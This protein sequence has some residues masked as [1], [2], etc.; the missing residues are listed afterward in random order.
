[1]PPRR[2]QPAADVD[3]VGREDLGDDP[4]VP[5]PLDRLAANLDPGRDGLEQGHHPA[6]VFLAL[7]PERLVQFGG[8]DAVQPHELPGHDDGVAVDDLGGAG[9]QN[10]TPAERQDG[11]ETS[12]HS[13]T[14]RCQ[15]SGGA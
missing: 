8:V 13:A 5:I 15:I 3:P 11:D 2:H 6:H 9:Q 1:M 14:V 12:E 7:P 10:G 4:A